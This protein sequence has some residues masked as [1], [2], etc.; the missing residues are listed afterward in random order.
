MEHLMDIAMAT[1]WMP[2]LGTAVGAILGIAGSLTAN[3]ASSWSAQKLA[4]DQRN[5]ELRTG[6][7]DV[8]KQQY[9]NLIHRG[10]TLIRQDEE[11]VSQ[12]GYGLVEWYE[13]HGDPIAAEKA[14]DAQLDRAYVDIQLTAPE[15]MVRA[16]GKY[17][18]SVYAAIWPTSGHEVLTVDES[19]ALLIQAT[20]AVTALPTVE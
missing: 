8:L 1:L 7:A 4:S 10:A 2:I 19:K 6:S 18:E 11:I 17:V 13:I 3:L 9:Y 16:A 14:F 20:R 15:P 5:H 12:H